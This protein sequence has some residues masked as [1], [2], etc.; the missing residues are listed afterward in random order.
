PRLDRR[1][2]GEAAH[3]RHLAQ[4]FGGGDPLLR[5]ELARPL[6]QGE[7]RMPLVQVEHGGLDPH[8]AERPVAADAEQDLLLDAGLLV[9]AVEAGG[10][11]P[12]GG[13]GW[14]GA[15][16]GGGGGVESS[17]ASRS[18]R[19]LRPA[20]TRQRRTK[21]SRPGSST[22]NRACPPAAASTG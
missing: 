21:T 3:R 5:D 17:R 13:G 8:H 22:L 14:G 20:R 11:L 7:R 18:R 15:G 2:G 12:V 6:Q 4:G 10:Q 16:V 9:A 1:V 19:W